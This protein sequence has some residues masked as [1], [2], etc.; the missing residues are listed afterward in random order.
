M[1][2]DDD[3]V[4]VDGVHYHAPTWPPPWFIRTNGKVFECTNYSRITDG[5][6]EDMTN[7]CRGAEYAPVD[8]L[9]QAGLTGVMNVELVRLNAVTLMDYI[10]RH[11]DYT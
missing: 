2:F 3:H 4:I 9:L 11:N 1:T 5:Q 8:P 10:E 7:V 6:R